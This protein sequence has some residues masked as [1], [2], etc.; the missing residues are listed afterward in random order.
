MHMNALKLLRFLQVAI[1]L[2]FD[3]A[4]FISISGSS[5]PGSVSLLLCQTALVQGPDTA[6][7]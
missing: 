4:R 1:S 5:R 2:E 7:V 3:F 6:T